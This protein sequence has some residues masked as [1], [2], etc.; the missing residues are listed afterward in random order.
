MSAFNDKKQFNQFA[1][2]P[3][4][5]EE[6]VLGITSKI[7]SSGQARMPVLVTIPELRAVLKNLIDQIQHNITVLSHKE[8]HPQ[9]AINHLGEV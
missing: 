7:K 9:F 4:Q 3:S 6:L 5:V 2:T 1:L 8:L